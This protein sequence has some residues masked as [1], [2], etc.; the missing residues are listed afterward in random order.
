MSDDQKHQFADLYEQ[1]GIFHPHN[2]GLMPTLA[3]HDGV[4][5]AIHPE[6]C[7]T[8]LNCPSCGVPIEITIEWPEI[9]AMKYGVNPYQVY[10][11]GQY[12]SLIQGQP[13]SWKFVAGEQ[14]WTPEMKCSQCSWASGLRV[15]PNELEPW[16]TEGRRRGY[17]NPNVEKQLSLLCDQVAQMLRAGAAPV[18]RR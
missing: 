14:A 11:Q 1:T 15:R 9:V 13:I 16:L 12:A 7:K 2:A 18:A 8:R 10:A 5:H 4:T 6:G 3:Q 17:F